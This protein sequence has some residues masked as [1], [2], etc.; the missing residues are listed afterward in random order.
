MAG[1]PTG[2]VGP[3]TVGL[4]IGGTKILGAVVAR[5]GRVLAEHRVLVPHGMREFDRAMADVARAI[6]P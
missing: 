5:D 3:P 4:D 1:L 6:G 2:A